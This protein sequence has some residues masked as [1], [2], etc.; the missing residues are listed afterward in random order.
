M[1]RPVNPFDRPPGDDEPPSGTGKQT[2]SFDGDDE[3]AFYALDGELDE[4]LGESP[5]DAPVD[6]PAPS[7]F[8]GA[9]VTSPFGGAA[10]ASSG[11]APLPAAPVP[12]TPEPATSAAPP[13]SAPAG[14][15]AVGGTSGSVRTAATVDAPAA[16]ALMEHDDEVV[17]LFTRT[18]FTPGSGPRV[19]LMP[20][21]IMTTR[22][23]RRAQRRGI[24]ALAGVVVLVVA[25][26]ALVSGERSV[27]R[28]D[29]AAA[30]QRSTEL[31][32][33]QSRYARAPQVYA[34]V[35][36]T[37]AAL[38]SVM[39]GDVRWYQYLADLAVTSPTGL[40]LTSWQASTSDPT[41]AP[42]TPDPTTG[43]PAAAAPVAALTISGTAADEPDVADWLDVLTATPG[44]AG[45]TASSLTRTAVGAEPVITF[46]SSAAM[47]RA[48]L[49]DRYAAKKD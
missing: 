48:A 28:D 11:D 42:T 27:A 33:E 19:S 20:T 2:F 46:D 38:A 17:G 39:A 21:E 24:L 7:S 40:W 29:L 23:V 12:F 44:L 16:V 35:D 14:T 4:A 41:L 32:T 1:D 22:R 15:P 26:Y 31:T 45:S 3:A 37:R 6:A 43:Q 8:D 47:T 34:Q 36:D 13:S 49:S 30:Q 9:P 25:A 5:D 10:T 18:S